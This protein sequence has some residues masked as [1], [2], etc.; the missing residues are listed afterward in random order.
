M[1][2]SGLRFVLTRPLGLNHE[3]QT[4]LED[5]G[6]M[7][8]TYPLLKIEPTSTP[9]PA[10][11][12]SADGLI[13]ISPSAVHQALPLLKSKHLPAP[14][15]WLAA[16]GKG[17]AQ[18]LQEYDLSATFCPQGTGD[19]AQLLELM[20]D[21]ARQRWGIIRG[22]GGRDLLHAEL[23]R[24]GADVVDWAV[25]WREPDLDMAA[26]LL[27]DLPTLDVLV[28]TSS[29]TVRMLF[30][31]AGESLIQQLQS[32]PIVVIHPRIA[33]AATALGAKQVFLASNVAELT[34][35]VADFL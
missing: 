4:A 5:R 24:R 14:T 33:E 18:A 2:L 31:Y 25:Y 1:S 29:E 12:L 9:M 3:W 13:F 17:T 21:V 22:E 35:V 26:R 16:M 27:Q 20:P 8:L 10:G 11:L 32:K 19:S 23:A 28:L 15:Q 7:V 34:K 6:G 30:A